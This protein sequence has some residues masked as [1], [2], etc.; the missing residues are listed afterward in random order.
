MENTMDLP[1]IHN[2]RTPADVFVEFV[3]GAG[4]FVFVVGMLTVILGWAK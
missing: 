4:L 1:R 2:R 3:A